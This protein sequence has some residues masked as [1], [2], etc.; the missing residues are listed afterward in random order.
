MAEETNGNEY[1][2]SEN[3]DGLYESLR[4]RIGK[5]VLIPVAASAAAAAVTYAAKKGPD[6][7]RGGTDRV[8]ESL[9][10][11]REGGGA[12]G[13]AAGAAAKAMGGKGNIAERLKQGGAKELEQEGAEAGGLKG[14][15]GKVLGKLAGSGDKAGGSGWGKGR[16]LPIIRGIDVAAPIETV[17]NQWTQFEDFKTF[18][19][20]VESV[21][22]E[23][24]NKVVWHENVWGRRRHWTTEIKE[25]VP[26]QKIQWEIQGGGRGTGVISFHKLAPRLTRLEV[27]FDWQPQGMVEKLASGMRFHKRAAKADLYRFKAFVE[28][29]GE[30]TGAWRGRI[31][32]GDVKGQPKNKRKAGTAEIPDK[33]HDESES[34]GNGDGGGDDDREQKRA[35][36]ER[37]RKEREKQLA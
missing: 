14:V 4:E 20:R 18:M 5:E 31:E 30:E 25:Q 36:R 6:L 23:D 8:K 24:D 19:H 7:L 28:T 10:S 1:G 26:N 35:E 27:V 3:R 9:D 12:K 32:D 2:D 11:A 16:R 34:A 17:Y 15:G 33:Q 22:Q 37:R 21:D 29:R 13:F